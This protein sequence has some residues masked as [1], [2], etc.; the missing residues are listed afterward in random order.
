MTEAHPGPRK[1][2]VGTSMYAMYG[3]AN[4]YPGLDGRLRE[5][6]EF[7]DET[8]RQAQERYG[9]G[10]DLAVFPEVAV[11]GGLDGM[12]ADVAFPLQGAV[13]ERMG[14]A[15]R[16]NGSYVVVPM[17]LEEEGGGY[18]NVC[19]LLDRAG[20]VVGTYRKVYPVSTHD[21]QVLEG[22]VTPGVEFPV[23]DCDFGRV[24]MQIC[25]DIQFEAGWQALA[26]AGAEIVAWPTMSPQLI[27]PATY[28]RQHGYYLVSST[29]RNNATIFWPNGMIAAQI[30]EPERL[31]VRQ[32]DLSY[33]LLGWQPALGN[34]SALR[35][36]YG[37]AV[38]F[39][40]SEAE[41]RGIFWSNDPERPIG[42][43]VDELGL[44]RQ[45]DC[46]ERNRCLQ[47]RLRATPAG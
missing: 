5:L 46:I 6:G 3:G 18:S 43:M 37:E 23:V 32:I 28:A 24:G 34:G 44:E 21:H 25:F 17:F 40:Y 38:G 7:V 4:P 42:R 15:A 30:T 14:E 1:V 41:D 31:L 2:V 22:G 45:A 11:N 35:S 39:D 10:L 20:E 26:E 13:L 47:D 19:V 16:R 29:W 8:G 12:A 33:E 9:R 27:Q 36:A